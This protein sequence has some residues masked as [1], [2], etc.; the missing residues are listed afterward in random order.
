MNET[1]RAQIRHQQRVEEL[2]AAS[3]RA[4]AGK[5][6][7][8]FRGQRLYNG[9]R[10]L[11]RFA[12]HLHPSHDGYTANG[13][14]DFDDFR[15]AADGLALR[16][17]HSD[18]GLHAG[19]CPGDPVERLLFDLLEQIR[20]EALA[21]PHLPG[22]RRNLRL[23]FERWSLAYH[24]SGL[25][26]SARGI[27]LYTAAQMCRSRV[28]GEPPL[29]LTEELIDPTRGMLVRRF[30]GDLYGLR[31]QR[32]D[33]A[34]Y[35][36]HALNIARVVAALMHSRDDE[37][38]DD[39]DDGEDPRS[40]FRLLFDREDSEDEGF[41]AANTQ[42]DGGRALDAAADS[43]RVY[44]RAY[45]REVDAATLARAAV[46]AEYR[47]RLDQRIAAQGINLPRL[48]RD[49]KVLLAVPTQDGWDGAQE[50]GI[51]D[52]RRLAQLVSAPA[53]RRLFRIDR[54]QPMADCVVTFLIDCSGSMRQ[55]IDSVAMLVDVLVRALE[56]AGVSSE[57]L[58]FTTGAWT[59]GRAQRDWQRAGRPANPGRLNEVCHMVFKAAD[60][61]WR[62][63][64][65]AIAALLKPDL[66]RE[67]IDG[68]AVEWACGRMASRDEERRL[69][70]VVSDGS[71]MDSATNLAN[72]PHYLDHHLRE[73]VLRHQQA[74][75]IAICGVGVGLDLSPYYRRSLAL[76]LS[77]P[78]GNRIFG[79]ILSM[80]AKM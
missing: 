40:T 28:S 26:E 17:T 51:I 55:H 61:P 21:A 1:T 31:R 41:A 16:L 43:Y 36:A 10:L 20:V 78:P 49:L 9:T 66:F 23:R 38:G 62:R 6:D 42:G 58:G 73:V 39:T 63:A 47:E 46:L 27:L 57:I 18:A 33:Q 32:H 8:H 60:T 45:D 25:N 75:D 80:I 69:L 77:A 56:M 11:P 64:R 34:A 54:W 14:E 19:L 67:G 48:A 7:L 2:C 79:E 70:L 68:E 76:D 65:P 30:G 35:A 22:V 37:R 13:P 24:H 50:E 3:I 52:G 29:A 59:G 4:L 71:P 44:T 74:G 53:E 15:G 5:A 12:L 72:E